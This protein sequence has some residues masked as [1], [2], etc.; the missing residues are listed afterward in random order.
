M[1]RRERDMR[2]QD[3]IHTNL[4]LSKGRGRTLGL[5]KTK[6]KKREKND[7]RHCRLFK[8]NFLGSQE[9]GIGI[10]LLQLY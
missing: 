4:W 3:K 5:R 6:K 7:L 2:R 10:A 8:L 9:V 1:R